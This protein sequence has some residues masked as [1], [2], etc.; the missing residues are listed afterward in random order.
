MFQFDELTDK[1]LEALAAALAVAEGKIKEGTAEKDQAWKDAFEIFSTHLGEEEAGRYIA[2]DGFTLS[3]Q[4]NTVQST[5]KQDE[6]MAGIQRYAN[7]QGW[8]QQQHTML[9]NSITVQGPRVLDQEKLAAAL[10]RRPYL[11][12]II[13][14]AMTEAGYNFSRVRRAT[15]KEDKQWLEL[16]QKAQKVAAAKAEVPAAEAPAKKKTGKLRDLIAG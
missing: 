7:E 4:K 8:S 2:S 3:K 11:G 6:L 16:R 5:L 13:S 9:I 12:P 10:K 1:R 15:S 14:E